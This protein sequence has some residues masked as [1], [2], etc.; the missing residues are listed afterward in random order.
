M[1]TT[2]DTRF[3]YLSEN[4]YEASYLIAKSFKVLGFIK[5]GRKVTVRFPKSL[6]LEQASL[7][8]FNGGV[9]SAIKFTDAYRRLKDAV[10][11][12]QNDYEEKNEQSYPKRT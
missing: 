12:T 7:N 9:V 10:F 3:E 11:T 4:L 6:E 5:R 2:E 8:Y 1:R